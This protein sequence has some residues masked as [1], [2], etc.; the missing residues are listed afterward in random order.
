MEHQTNIRVRYGETDKMG[1]VYHPNYL[2]YFEI[3]R[4]ELMRSAGIAYDRVEKSGVYLVLVDIGIKYRGT[5][6]YDD[7]LVVTTRLTDVRHTTIRFDYTIH[8]R[9]TDKKITEGYTVLASV[10]NNMKVVRLPRELNSL[11]H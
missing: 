6:L 5:A 7:E 2:A 11:I 1:V 4:T 3:G 9:R 10:D 8:N